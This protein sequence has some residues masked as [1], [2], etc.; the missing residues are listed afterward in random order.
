MAA[1]SERSCLWRCYALSCLVFPPPPVYYCVAA[2]APAH[3][4]DIIALAIKKRRKLCA[5]H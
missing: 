4:I 2:E 1:A 5:L 3:E